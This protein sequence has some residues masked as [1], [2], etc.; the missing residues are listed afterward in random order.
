VKSDL[1][2]EKIGFKIREHTIEHVPYLLVVGDREVESRTV[3]VR[4]QDGTDLGIMPIGSYVE[5]LHAEIAR[6]GRIE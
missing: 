1:R 2:N 4:T 6:R 3:S 5:L